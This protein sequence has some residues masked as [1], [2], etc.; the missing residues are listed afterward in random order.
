MRRGYDSS[1]FARRLDAIRG[2]LGD[3]VHIST[4]IMVGFPGESDDAFG[5]SVRFLEKFSFG[6]VHVF[7]FS[8]REG[9]RAAA[10]P[11][12]IPRNV[13]RERVRTVIGVSERLLSSYAGRFVG[14]ECRVVAE[15]GNS[16]V[17]AGWNRHYVKVFSRALRADSRW[18][19]LPLIP[20]RQAGGMLLCPGV[21]IEDISAMQ[22]E[23]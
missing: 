6:R 3:G 18:A 16:E 13:V 5:N 14:R 21:A 7:P 20:E 23:F 15:D 11:G 8:P 10:M 19:E 22:E 9:T 17:V 2:F 12:I 1:G 4:D